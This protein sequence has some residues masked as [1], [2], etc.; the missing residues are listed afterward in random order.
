MT[1]AN[2]PQT[3]A[4]P[5]TPYLPAQPL[6]PADER[7]WAM[8][9]HLSVLVNL[10]T[11]FLG[12]LVALIIYLVFRERS[13][14]VAYQAMQSFLFQLIAWVGGGTLAVVLWAAGGI[15]SVICVGVLLFPLAIAASLIP[16]AAI[17]YG[18]F[19]GVE[20]YQGKDFRYWLVGDWVRGTLS[21]TT[22]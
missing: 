12:P 2:P 1:Q 10:F 3:P 14:Y 11:G 4:P 9:A 15:L 6:S 8:L 21:N 20:T 19:A 5:P 17:V 7:T 18:I 22:F 13:R 16:I